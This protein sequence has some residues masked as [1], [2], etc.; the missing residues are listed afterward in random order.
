M[1]S[2]G[3]IFCV[4]CERQVAKNQSRRVAGRK[5]LAVCT[6][7]HA[8]WQQLG[9]QCQRCKTRVVD[10]RDVGVFLDRYALGHLDCGAGG[11]EPGRNGR[12][13]VDAAAG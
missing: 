3:T 2:F 4:L 7:C 13:W 8:R 9:S 6:S 10:E 5:D 12:S 11:L 1:F